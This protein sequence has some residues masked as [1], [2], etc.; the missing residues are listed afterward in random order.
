MVRWSRAFI[1]HL[2]R[3]SAGRHAISSNERHLWG[4][5]HPNQGTGPGHHQISERQWV[6]H[7]SMQSQW[8]TWL[9]QANI[10]LDTYLMEVPHTFHKQFIY[11][12]MVFKY[13]VLYMMFR[14]KV[15][16]LKYGK[17]PGKY[18]IAHFICAVLVSINLHTNHMTSHFFKLTSS[19]PSMDLITKTSS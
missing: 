7:W 11:N 3:K 6:Q 14:I 1:C 12:I 15:T 5:G 19:A 16:P 17:L 10:V 13:F 4:W 18:S 9:Q 8:G 2:K